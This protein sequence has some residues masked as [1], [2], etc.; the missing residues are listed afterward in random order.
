M[1]AVESIRAGVWLEAGAWLWVEAGSRPGGRLTFFA[2]PRKVS[3]RRRARCQRP[4]EQRRATCAAQIAGESMQTR[5]AQ[6]G[7]LSDPRNIALLGAGSTGLGKTKTGVS[8]VR[9]AGAKVV[10]QKDRGVKAKAKAKVAT[11]TGTGTGTEVGASPG[12]TRQEP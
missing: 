10:R 6:T 4:I 12:S 7:M 8:V 2:S 1:A 9:S 11:S 5:C 3:K